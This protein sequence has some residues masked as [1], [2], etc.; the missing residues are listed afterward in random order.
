MRG[1]QFASFGRRP[2]ESEPEPPATLVPA[3]PAVHLPVVFVADQASLAA[4]GAQVA[5]VVG[6]AILDAI[7][8]AAGGLPSGLTPDLD[9]VGV[10]P[11][12]GPSV[13]QLADLTR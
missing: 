7:D 13:E 6:Q 1:D 11:C 5:A 8:A 9:E 12:V 3:L 10:T 4:L 2:V